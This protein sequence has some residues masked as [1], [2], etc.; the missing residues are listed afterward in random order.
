M[1][2]LLSSHSYVICSEVHLATE[3]QHLN[4]PIKKKV[5]LILLKSAHESQS[6]NLFSSTCET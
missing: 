4:L 2:I 1:L 3:F 5:F 6:D